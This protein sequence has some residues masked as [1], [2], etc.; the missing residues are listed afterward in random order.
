MRVP[1]PPP[2]MNRARVND[3]I[4]VSSVRLINAE[5]E[6][7]GVVS[8]DDARRA[9]QEA[10]LDLVEVAPNARP[11]VCRI[12]DYGKFLFEQQKKERAQKKRQASTDVKEIRLRPGTG[13]GDMEIKAR[14]AREFIADGHKVGIQ[15]QFRGRERAHP[16]IAIEVIDAFAKMLE[17]VAK[18]E[19][20]PRQEGRRMNAVLAPIKKA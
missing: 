20:A 13:K 17:D 10:E 11:P 18:M 3:K 9:A 4:R 19:Q 6:Q 14:H 5:G 16:E 2:D 7:L 1:V 8:I 12:M 15:L